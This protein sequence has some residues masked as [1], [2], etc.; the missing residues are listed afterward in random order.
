MKQRRQAGKPFPSSQH[1]GQTSLMSL[2]PFFRLAKSYSLPFLRSLLTSLTKQ[3]SEIF[4]A[5]FSQ[6]F[7]T[8]YF[9]HSSCLYFCGWVLFICFFSVCCGTSGSLGSGCLDF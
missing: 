6:H 5:M 8:K 7:F 2:Y 9:R 3:N 4:P 1:G